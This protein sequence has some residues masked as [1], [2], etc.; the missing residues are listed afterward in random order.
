VPDLQIGE[1]HATLAASI[2]SRTCGCAALTKG[3]GDEWKGAVFRL[4]VHHRLPQAVDASQSSHFCK[5]ILERRGQLTVQWPWPGGIDL[6]ASPCCLLDCHRA[7]LE[8]VVVLET[9]ALSLAPQRRRSIASAPHWQ[10]CWTGDRVVEG[11]AWGAQSRVAPRRPQTA[12]ER[13]LRLPP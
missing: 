10:T 11:A 5:L 2:S 8:K 13:V 6:R 3:K 1:P 7:S 9:A 12:S 4:P